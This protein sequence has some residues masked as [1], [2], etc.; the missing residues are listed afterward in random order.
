MDV[1]IRKVRPADDEELTRFYRDLSPES[2]RA[3]FLG[4]NQGI[5]GRAARAFCTL[6]HMHDE[7]LV[8]VLNDPANPGIVGHVCLL[9]AGG[10]SVEIGICVADAFQELGIGRRLFERA[11]LWARHRGSK[12]MTAACAADNYRVLALLSSAPRGSTRTYTDAGT[13]DVNI[14]LV[15]EIPSAHESWPTAA[16]A[17]LVCRRRMHRHQNPHDGPLHLFRLTR[18]TGRVLLT[19]KEA[20]R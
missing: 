13:V 10:G 18:R 8:A 5:T 6:D 16:M 19:S 20:S 3:R 15:G 7:G 11:I 9:D 1:L 12:S 14:P 17:A 4:A 2:R